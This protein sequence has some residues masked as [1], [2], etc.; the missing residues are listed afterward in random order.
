[1][2]ILNWGNTFVP[3]LKD[4]TAILIPEAV[5][6]DTKIR[7]LDFYAVLALENIPCT[8]IEEFIGT[9]S[10]TYTDQDIY[11]EV[12]ISSPNR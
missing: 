5:A 1:M 12:H 4:L 3:S 11:F 7:L 8:P 9:E 6:T 10:G 2:T